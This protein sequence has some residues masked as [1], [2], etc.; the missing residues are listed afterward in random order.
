M[1]LIR[2]QAGSHVEFRAARGEWTAGRKSVK[3]KNRNTRAEISLKIFEVIDVFF[4][5]TNRDIY[6]RGMSDVL[7]NTPRKKEE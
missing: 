4:V 3:T 1:D 5:L 7:F 6:L 2:S